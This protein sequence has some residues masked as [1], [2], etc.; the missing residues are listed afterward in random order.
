[1][2]SVVEG[3][4]SVRLQMVVREKRGRGKGREKREGVLVDAGASTFENL[5][6]R[7][8][9]QRRGTLA[10]ENRT[11]RLD[12]GVRIN[13]G[14]ESK[15]AP[16]VVANDERHG[17]VVMGGLPHRSGGSQPTLTLDGRCKT[18]EPLP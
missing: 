6:R 18:T 12:H 10:A 8:R 16:L 11:K 9:W 13:N 2:C 15:A 4:E 14:C 5:L 3:S 1:M 7:V 17:S